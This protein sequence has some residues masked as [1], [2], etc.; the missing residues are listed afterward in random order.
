MNRLH[1]QI[2][3]GIC[4]I[5][6]ASIIMPAA[7]LA[8][9]LVAGLTF[10]AADNCRIVVNGKRATLADLKVGGTVSIRYRKANGTLI[11][12]RVVVRSIDP[13]PPTGDAP[14]KGQ[15]QPPLNLS[16]DLLMRGTITSVNLQANTI[17]ITGKLGNQAE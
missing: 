2:A 9:G 16:N 4:L 7:L 6:G 15:H 11:A 10:A 12:D 8:R 17:T 13:A 5:A 3:V 14:P 1:R